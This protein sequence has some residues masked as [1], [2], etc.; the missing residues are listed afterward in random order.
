MAFKLRGVSNDSSGQPS[1]ECLMEN[2]YSSEWLSE[3]D[4]KSAE[5]LRMAR[6]ATDGALD[7]AD[8]L[9]A[10]SI[11]ISQRDNARHCAETFRRK[12]KELGH[13]YL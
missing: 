10:V 4:R 13:E 9:C 7:G 2:P 6:E 5:A 3:S 11:L 1:V 8:I 12:L